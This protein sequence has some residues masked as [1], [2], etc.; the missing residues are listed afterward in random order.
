MS[1]HQ[2]FSGLRYAAHAAI[3]IPMMV[4]IPGVM[5]LRDFGH[6]LNV[7]MAICFFILAGSIALSSPQ[8]TMSPHGWYRGIVGNP[9]ALGHFSAIGLLLF[10]HAFLSSNRLLKRRIFGG[11]ALLAFAMLLWSYA[12]SSAIAA[13]VGLAVLYVFHRSAVSKN[14]AIAF[15]SLGISLI[16]IP[17]LL[18]ALE[19]RIVKHD[20]IDS[21]S[22]LADRILQSRSFV[23]E[24]SL[25]AFWE[26]PIFGWGF[27]VDADT[28]LATWSGQ[29]TSTGFTGRD[30]VNDMLYT[31]ETGGVIGFFAYFLLLALILRVW[32]QRHG[33][34]VLAVIEPEGHGLA[35]HYV[36]FLSLTVTLAVLFQFDN[37]ALAAGNFFGVLFWLSLGCSLALAVH[38]RSETRRLGFFLRAGSARFKQCIVV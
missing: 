18:E 8:P 14:F 37:T 36:A 24:R 26:R 32:R 12:R 22:N 4:L 25:E 20:V 19:K 23:F 29:L 15:G 38:V 6:L 28:D 3:L 35:R 5:T 33:A 1:D 34:K 2:S 9:N 13:F 30:P 7:F 11:L 21:S 17:G 31:L 27:G 10:S 16:F